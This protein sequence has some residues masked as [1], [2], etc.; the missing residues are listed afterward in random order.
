MVFKKIYEVCKPRSKVKSS[1]MV[2]SLLAFGC[3]GG[4]GSGADNSNNIPTN[5]PVVNE[6]R[7]DSL[8]QAI[9]LAE[10]AGFTSVTSS[11]RKEMFSNGAELSGNSPSQV[12]RDHDQMSKLLGLFSQPSSADLKS[13]SANPVGFVDY[14][15]VFE[16]G[17]TKKEEFMNRLIEIEKA[18][19][20]TVVKPNSV[21]QVLSVEEGE[22][23]RVKVETVDGENVTHA[24]FNVNGKVFPALYDVGTNSF[25]A[26]IHSNNVGENLIEFFTTN[27][28]DVSN[29]FMIGTLKV[30]EDSNLPPY[31]VE[32]GDFDNDDLTR[33]RVEEGSEILANIK[34]ATFKDDSG[35]SPTIFI[36][37]Q[38]PDKSSDW[39]IFDGKIDFGGLNFGPNKIYMKAID[40]EGLESKVFAANID[41][42]RYVPAPSPSP[43]PT[44]TNEAPYVVEKGDF[45]G[46]AKTI[47]EGE[48]GSFSLN[49]VNYA[50]PDGDSVKSYVK[51]NDGSWQEFS[52]S[53]DFGGLDWGENKI[54][55]KG[56][57]SSLESE[58]SQANVFYDSMLEVTDV[59]DFDGD[60]A[61]YQLDDRNIRSLLLPVAVDKDNKGSDGIDRYEI[62]YENTGSYKTPFLYKTL[63]S[64]DTKWDFIP[65]DL[66]DAYGSEAG[67]VT[68]KG[69]DDEGSEKA[70]GQKVIDYW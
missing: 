11:E 15:L 61:T 2:L 45:N 38:N 13:D 66:T 35:V 29:Q 8:E 9:K 1:A 33:K 36:N 18:Q 68:V 65:R 7:V 70:L 4:G 3:S 57:D 39:H 27:T 10:E 54:Y 34:S 63:N 41:Y 51:Y 6:E 49:P 42:Q 28:E 43:T 44:P 31:V 22:D 48:E 50:D 14:S 46:S 5:P 21:N 37:Y 26:D 69:F 52:G 64:S 59:K 20:P 47:K 67:R 23:V 56:S 55:M 53:F 25:S 16:P 32:K 19:D 62:W 40:E 30:L 17:V 58:V 24:E 60:L 12:F